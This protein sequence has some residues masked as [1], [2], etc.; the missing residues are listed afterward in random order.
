MVHAFY[1]C[2]VIYEWMSCYQFLRDAVMFIALKGN[3][4]VLHATRGQS[5]QE[6]IVQ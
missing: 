5:L 3:V 1:K 6:G 4:S 2:E